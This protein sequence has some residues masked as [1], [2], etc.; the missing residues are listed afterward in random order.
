MLSAGLPAI[1]QEISLIPRG[2]RLAHVAVVLVVAGLVT[3]T[4]TS[5]R[6][7]HTVV[8]QEFDFDQD[9][10]VGLAHDGGALIT[11]WTGR[12]FDEVTPGAY[13]TTPTDQDQAFVVKTDP[14]GRVDW[15]TYFG[16]DGTVGTAL[17]TD[18][19]GDVYL[20]GDVLDADYLPTTAG[21]VGGHYART[22][23]ESIGFVAK[24]SADGSTLDW[25]TLLPGTAH[26][27]DLVV[28]NQDR[29][30]V[31][32]E[33]YPDFP[34]T[35]DAF[36]KAEISDPP[37]LAYY[38][39][40]VA[41][42]AADG[43]SFE[44]ASFIG[45]SDFDFALDVDLGPGGS[46][47]LSGTTDSSD[48]PVT[49]GAFQTTTTDTRND[50]VAR[51]DAD[52]S[53][54]WA[55]YLGG[56]AN[57]SVQDW[58]SGVSVQSD[59]SVVV[60]SDGNDP[61][62]PT[63]P[64]APWPT[65]VPGSNQY[66]AGWAAEVSKDGSSLDWATFI[67]GASREPYVDRRGHVHLLGVGPGAGYPV[68]GETWSSARVELDHDGQLVTAS[69][70][71]SQPLDIVGD[72]AGGAYLIGEP[73]TPTTR[74]ASNPIVSFQRVVPCTISGTSGDDVLEGT[75]GP[76]VICAKGGDDVVHGGGGYD[77]ILLGAGDDT[78]YAGGGIDLVHGGSGDDRIRGGDDRDLVTGGPGVDHLR[79]DGGDDTLVGGAGHDVLRG[80]SGKDEL[81][82]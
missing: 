28:D 63:T 22:P 25:A 81:K 71:S 6:A 48:F 53:L 26:V 4:T 36:D 43:S 15:G 67:P 70:V 51:V 82:P 79:G 72:P 5:A 64:D 9:W 52:G 66:A 65:P 11:G 49:P 75:P 17:G 39:G 80:G 46:T 55:T 18:S 68:A 76:D 77:V 74:T 7:D 44:H 33:A 21:V 37:V 54:D 45:G 41:T 27:F 59:G 78:A 31:V 14:T 24:L 38:D 47:Y 42:L 20:G 10:A 62:F 1:G 8:V 30:H 23:G 57:G 60:T 50:F 32:G 34:V 61:T 13:D 73:Q 3:A 29:I 35:D 56:G 2:R 69:P 19:K 40:F 58:A 16:G 12:T